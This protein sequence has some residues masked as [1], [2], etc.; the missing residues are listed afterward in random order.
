MFTIA[1]RLSR[2][3]IVRMLNRHRL[4]AEKLEF[5]VRA[6]LKSFIYAARGLRWLAQDEHNAW[7]HLAASAAVIASGFMLHVSLDDWRWLVAA[8]TLVWVAEAI[9]TAIEELCDR[10]SS[11]FD[12]SIGRVKDL[13]A[14]A[15]LV[16][17]LGAVVI[18][19]LTLGPPLLRWLD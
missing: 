18:G 15:V 6:R 8:I 2:C 1:T 5:S 17:S 14:G 9:N 13:A 19:L 16:A 7:L 11:E 3:N 4:P 10:V 12:P